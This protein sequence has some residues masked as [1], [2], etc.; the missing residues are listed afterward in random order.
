MVSK[1]KP[2]ETVKQGLDILVKQKAI[3]VKAEI[4]IRKQ[5]IIDYYSAAV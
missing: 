1:I 3:S 5:F 2:A 4:I